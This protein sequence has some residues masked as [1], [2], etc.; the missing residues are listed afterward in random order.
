MNEL[1]RHPF[2]EGVVWEGLEN[3]QA[4]ELMPYLP[5]TEG[6]PEFW[7]SQARVRTLSPGVFFWLDGSVQSRMI[8]LCLC[9]SSV[10]VSGVQATAVNVWYDN[11]KI[12]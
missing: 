9:T 8:G 12:M 5:A 6:N 2:F 3:Q 11:K 10:Y 7:S 4:P 1:R